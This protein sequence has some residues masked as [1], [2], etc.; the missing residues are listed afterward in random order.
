MWTKFPQNPMVYNCFPPFAR[1]S[2]TFP[3]IT[4][5]NSLKYA[6]I[7]CSGPCSK[8]LYYLNYSGVDPKTNQKLSKTPI[9][10]APNTHLWIVPS[11]SRLL[12]D[13]HEFVEC[14]FCCRDLLLYLYILLQNCVDCV[15]N[16]LILDILDTLFNY[17]LDYTSSHC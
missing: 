10:Q 14:L 3:P 17:L 2:I 12:P 5:F 7:T 1:H 11:H 16:N 6:P 13:R 9:Q 4:R 15:H 8:F